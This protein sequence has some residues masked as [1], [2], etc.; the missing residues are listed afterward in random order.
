MTTNDE[1][2]TDAC[3][4]SLARQRKR[5]AAKCARA[6]KAARKKF[7]KWIPMAK[8]RPPE[9]RVLVVREVANGNRYIDM[10]SWWHDDPCGLPA[11]S[12]LQNVTHWMPL[13][14]LPEASK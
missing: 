5:F 12:S 1:V 4:E 11:I 3:D 6:A 14:E 7:G 8:Q 2:F 13:P 9:A 10:A